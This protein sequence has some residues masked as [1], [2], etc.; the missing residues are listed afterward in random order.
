MLQPVLISCLN[1]LPTS[2][3]NHRP[4]GRFLLRSYILGPPASLRTPGVQRLAPLCLYQRLIR[5]LGEAEFK[6]L[7]FGSPRLG[8]PTLPLSLPHWHYLVLG[9]QEDLGWRG[10]SLGDLSVLSISRHIHACLGSR[11]IQVKDLCLEVVVILA[12]VPRAGLAL[13]RL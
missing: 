13:L 10:P 6:S 8:F 5:I 9:D 12:N 2:A 7:S 11:S 1:H 4:P 3:P